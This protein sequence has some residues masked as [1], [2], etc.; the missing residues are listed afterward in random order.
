MGRETGEFG[1]SWSLKDHLCQVQTILQALG[2]EEGQIQQE[3]KTSLEAIW[4]LNVGWAGAGRENPQL[5]VHCCPG[6]QTCFGSEVTSMQQAL[7]QVL[8]TQV[9]NTD[10][11]P[12]PVGLLFQ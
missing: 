7:F 4:G 11:I 6:V 3:E 2:A 5:G 10:E 9:N 1:L 8:G 12:T